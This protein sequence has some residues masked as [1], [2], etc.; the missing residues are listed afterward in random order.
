MS[1]SNYDFITVKYVIKFCW[2]KLGQK[3]PILEA[4]FSSVPINTYMQMDT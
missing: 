1:P 3:K 2:S 4:M